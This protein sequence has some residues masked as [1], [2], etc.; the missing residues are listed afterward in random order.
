MNKYFLYLQR[1]SPTLIRISLGI[2][3]I[4]F[5]ALK[6]FNVSPVAGLVSTTYPNFP[7]PFF[8]TFLGI[9]EVVIGIGLLGNFFMKIIILLLLLQMGGIF[10]GLF[11]RPNL[12]FQNGNI[13]FLTANG[14]FVIKNL[15]LI[16]GALF[17][18]P[19][20]N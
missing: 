16:S 10:S 9:W 5:G 12:Y 11:L 19:R 20:K 7:E 17:L 14:E 3:Y 15:V 1:N 18:W 13:L 2:V 8:L 6:I 4:W